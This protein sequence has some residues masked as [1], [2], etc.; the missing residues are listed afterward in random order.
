M[1]KRLFVLALALIV[2]L[3]YVAFAS[4]GIQT[5]TVP[6]D[7]QITILV[8]LNTGDTVLGTIVVLGGGSNDVNFII[9]DSTGNT[10]LSNQHITAT[11]FSFSASTT[12]T[13]VMHFDNTFST[14]ASKEVN[15]NYYVQPAVFNIPANTF[16]LVVLIIIG[17]VVIGAI[18]GALVT[19]MRHHHK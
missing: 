15:L 19:R 13:Y 8:D 11:S 6:A 10:Q 14:S 9:T 16:L 17:L 5:F 2:L 1:P 12:G 4:C 18:A 7:Q 3:T